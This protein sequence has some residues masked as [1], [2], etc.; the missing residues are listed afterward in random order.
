[1]RKLRNDSPRLTSQ[2]KV[3]TNALVT[4]ALYELQLKAPLKIRDAAMTL[5]EQY[6]REEWPNAD[7]LLLFK[8]SDF[9][10]VTW[11]KFKKAYRESW[12]TGVESLRR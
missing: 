3:R 9:D 1:M 6:F 8:L 10:A 2:T 12:S 7:E 4:S 5:K 11:A